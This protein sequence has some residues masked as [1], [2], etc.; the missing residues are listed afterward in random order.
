MLGGAPA[1]S[2]S[3]YYRGMGKW[4]SGCPWT[5][6]MVFEEV[7]SETQLWIVWCFVLWR[8]ISVHVLNKSALIIFL[9][10]LSDC[11]FSICGH[12]GPHWARPCQPQLGTIFVLEFAILYW[13]NTLGKSDRVRS[14]GFYHWCISALY[15][16]CASL[17]KDTQK[18]SQRG[19]Y[20]CY[21]VRNLSPHPS[22]FWDTHGLPVY[23]F[24]GSEIY[25]RFYKQKEIFLLNLIYQPFLLWFVVSFP[26]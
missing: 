15:H 7:S 22:H 13:P 3:P 2:S 18:L 14:F 6:S 1:T 10:Y 21:Q 25:W 17:G 20:Y 5:G 23:V 9:S 24:P 4:R 12:S 26:E 16:F 19:T 11:K 8:L